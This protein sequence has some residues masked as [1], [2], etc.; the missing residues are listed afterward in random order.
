MRRSI[1]A[2]CAAT[3]AMVCGLSA[4]AQQHAQFP[5]NRPITIVIGV[6]AGGGADTIARLIGP[7]LQEAFG[8]PIVV[9]P[10]PGGNFLNSVRPVTSAAPDGH[11][12]L[13]ATSGYSMIAAKPNPPFDLVND[14]SP[15][16]L[17]ARG[18][19]I[20][21]ASPKLPV[22][23][24]PE[25]IAYAKANPGKLSFGSGGTGT[26]FH[27]AGEFFKTMTKTNTF[28]VPY[29]GSVPALQDVM[30]GHIDFVFDNIGPLIS[31]V[32]AGNVKALAVTTPQRVA[33]LPDVPTFAE[34]GY[35]DFNVSQWYGLVAPPKM[36][37][38]IVA[39]IRE[40]VVQ[41][42]KSKQVA[43]RLGTLGTEGVG[44]DPAA[45]RDVLAGEV[46]RWRLVIKESGLDLQ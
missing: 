6:P 1:V 34:L 8:Q 37:P 10:R 31:A 24:V 32:K 25:L 17:V 22:N 16:S 20:L 41:A 9:E 42:L 39:R 36:P 43:E 12:L 38:A 26:L 21:V 28:H 19:V 3:V 7:R 14:F 45:F 44:S 15:V 11:T 27:L 18:H 33:A 4:Q 2:A 46:A 5:S 40:E 23:S 29:K 13:M 30:G 35:P